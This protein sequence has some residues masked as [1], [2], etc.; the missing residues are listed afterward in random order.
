MLS[1]LII[2]LFGFLECKILILL[3]YIAC[4]IILLGDKILIPILGI[5]ISWFHGPSL[6][7]PHHGFTSM[8][9]KSL[10]LE[11]V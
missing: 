2:L 10:F 11:D 6:E 5:E 3:S 9:D 8:D 1:R 7:F 4:S